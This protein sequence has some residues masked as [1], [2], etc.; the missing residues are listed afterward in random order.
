MKYLYLFLVC[1]L[2]LCGIAQQKDT[3]V[4]VT[5]AQLVGIWQRDSYVVGAGLGCYFQFFKDGRFA[6][7]TNEYDEVHRIKSVNGTYRTDGYFIYI[8]MKYTHELQGG[9]LE[10]NETAFKSGLFYL[11]NGKCVDVPVKDSTTEYAWTLKK[12]KGKGIVIQDGKY[13][14]VDNNPANIG[15]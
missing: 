11:E 1:T 7:H 3:N 2:P 14:K 9:T 12:G 5:K 10:F 8:K 13:Y 4:V 6:W 15:Y